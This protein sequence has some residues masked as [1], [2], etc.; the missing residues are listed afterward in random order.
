MR[1]LAKKGYLIGLILCLVVITLLQVD[2]LHHFRT[3][4]AFNTGHENL[5]CKECHEAATGTIRQQTQA[6]MAFLFGQ[7]PKP[8]AFNFVTPNNKDCL[9]CHDRENDRHP[10]YRF[11]E[12]RFLEARQ[13]IQ[14]QHCYSC[15]KEHTGVRVSSKPENCQYC[16]EE[17]EVKNDPL[18]TSHHDLIKGKEWGTCLA[19]HDFHGNHQR[20][21]PTNN[22]DMLEI[23]VIHEYFEGGKDPY[24]NEKIEKSKETRY[25]N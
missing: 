22:K 17:I 4:G 7:K 25:E 21:T 20:K 14:P 19:C 23:K 24:S 6:N 15:H 12:P 10:V 13:A 11:N 3:P 2:S 5:A 9:A 8:V 16:H 18:D 1:S